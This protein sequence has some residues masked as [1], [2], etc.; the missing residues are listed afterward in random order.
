MRARVSVFLSLAPATVALLV[1]CQ[2]PDD[3]AAPRLPTDPTAAVGSAG[4]NAPSNVTALA[5]SKTEIDLGWQDNTPNETGFEVQRST[6]GESGPFTALATVGANVGTYRDEGLAPLTR[7]CYR[8]RAVRVRPTSTTSSAFSTPACATTRTDPS[9]TVVPDSAFV[10]VG[11]ASSFRAEVRDDRGALIDAP[12]TWATSDAA[13]ATVSATGRATGVARGRATITATSQGKSD[14]AQLAVLAPVRVTTSTTGIDLDP[15]G[16]YLSVD[17]SSY[18]QLGLNA[19]I[20]VGLGP[21]DHLVGLGNLAPNCSVGGE[22][23]RRVNISPDA[24]THVSF[25]I[26]CVAAYQLAY[27]GWVPCYP[28]G[29]CNS[30]GSRSSRVLI[31]PYPDGDRR[32]NGGVEPAWSPDGR[33][34]AFTDSS[35]EVAVLNPA[36]GS[37]TALT[38]H[39]AH[40]GAPD[41]SPDGGRIAFA[42]NRDGLAELYLMNADGSSPV[43]VTNGVGFAGSPAWSPD[44]RRIAFNCVVESG[45]D[46][47]CAVNVDGSGFARLTSDPPSDYG[48]AWSPDGRKI[49]FATER[50]APLMSEIAILNLDGMAVSRLAAGV[51][52]SEPAW[53]PDGNRIA[54]TTWVEG[55]GMWDCPH[56]VVIRADGTGLMTGLVEFASDAAWRPRSPGQ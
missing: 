38:Q 30:D 49:A 35:G 54:F 6:T 4:L 29:P 44:G 27:V 15:D 31:V 34:I 12:V 17:G 51:N 2:D 25:E 33:M 7:Y 8:I 14:S 50:Y 53:S 20:S 21:G 16:Y 3:P 11:E 10:I 41:W 47:I 19:T 26:L 55:C 40:D 48:P 18:G 22:Y 5:P 39:P 45:N 32:V 28:P 42:S 13:V 23:P 36:T 46:D 1:G 56:I 52:G 24:D 43:R 9:V 37:I